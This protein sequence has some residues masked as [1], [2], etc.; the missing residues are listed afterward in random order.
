[1]TAPMVEE[2]AASRTGAAT[3]C[4][5]CALQCAMTVTP[6]TAEMAVDVQPRDFPTNRGGLCHKGW[7]SASLLDHPDRLRVPLVRDAAGEL[8]PS[9][10]DE[11]YARIVAGVHR[12]RVRGG[13]NGVAVF[14]GGG[15]TNEKAY[16]LGK[17]A[18]VG[19]GTAMIDYNGR[20]CMSS[21]AAGAARSIGM[22]RGLPFPVADLDSAGAVLLVGSNPA[23]TMPPFVQHL[24]SCRE[25]GGL[26]VID[27]RRTPTAALTADAAG[28]HLQPLPGT[29]VTVLLGLLHLVVVRGET[30]ETY[31]A[32]RVDGWDTVRRAAMMWWPE[33]VERA[34]GVPVSELRSAA[35]ILTAA[36]PASGGHGAYVLTGRGAEQH[37]HGTDTVNAAINLA[38]ALGLPGR[39]G[40]GYGCLTGQGN[41]QGGR[42]HGQKCDQLPGYRKITDPAARAHVAAVWGVEPSDIPGPG[43]PAVQLLDS[44]GQV[45]SAG[46][47]SGP[48]MLFVHGAN[49]VVSGPN[50]TTIAKRFEALDTLVVTDFVLSETAAMADVVLPSLQW[51]EEEGTM[52]NLEGRV[53]RRRRSVVMD[54]PNGPRD[55]LRIW[56]DLA[57]LLVAPARFVTEPA[58]VFDELARASAGGLADYSGLSHALLDRL[59]LGSGSTPAGE[60]ERAAYWPAPARGSD[61]SDAQTVERMPALLDGSADAETPAN[62]PDTPTRRATGSVGTPRLFLDRFATPNGRATMIDVRASDVEDDVRPDAPLYLITGRVLQHYQSGAQTRRV[63]ELVAGEP[64]AFAQLHPLTADRFSI[65]EGDDVAVTTRFGRVVAAARL[66][67]DIRRDCVFVPFHFAGSATANRATNPALDPIS[68]MPE[69]KVCAASIRAVRIGRSD[70]DEGAKA[71]RAGSASPLPSEGLHTPGSASHGAWRVAGV[72]S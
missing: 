71:E 65:E 8:V 20:F 44:L 57:R 48:T 66:S 21:A 54:D 4:P 46:Q 45:D 52:T 34:T 19:L 9:S 31:L 56:S 15:L 35:A 42:E 11:A 2:D 18:R 72:A 1:M 32:E 37:A 67:N 64:R 40:S 41:G 53:L 36:S 38:L 26:V 25:R 17:F 7:T 24:R 55:E 61:D 63:P 68:S 3:H 22:D 29:D 23:E 12:A 59:E 47:A 49:P 6:A 50:S 30:D 33:A 28:M 16:T 27:P 51:A 70:A 69:F 14:G 10:W 58:E 5:Y 13:P 39:V 62:H 60:D 43:I